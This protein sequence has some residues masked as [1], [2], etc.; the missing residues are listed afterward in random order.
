MEFKGNLL[1]SPA[2]EAPV[3]DGEVVTAIRALADR[4]VGKTT[5]ARDVGV[6]IN[7]V[8]RY[9]RRPVEAGHHVRPA[10]RRLTDAWRD[11]A[12][13]LYAGP[14]GGNAVVGQRL[15]GELGLVISPDTPPPSLANA[16]SV[17]AGV[18]CRAS[19]D[20][21]SAHRDLARVLPSTLPCLA[22]R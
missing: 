16:P 14:A 21:P 19:R 20:A 8:R 7:T 4:G 22:R 6:S 2:G 10:A 11:G 17:A 1:V 5:I 3:I 12:H 13:A 15:L 18:V 9:V